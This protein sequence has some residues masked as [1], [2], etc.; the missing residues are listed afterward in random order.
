MKI[1]D[2]EW[3]KE[4]IGRT[5]FEVEIEKDDSFSP[6][7]LR[8]VP[9]CDYLVVKVPAGMTP[10]NWFLGGQHFTCTEMQIKYSKQIADFDPD[11]RFIRKILPR[12]TY[13]IV[14]NLAAAELITER[15]TPD[16]FRT[17]RISLDPHF[18]PETGC[19]RYRNYLMNSYRTGQNEIIGVYFDGILAGFE[20]YA[21]EGDVCH[22]KLGGIYPDVKVPGLGFLVTCTPLLFTSE[23]YGARSFVADV[24]ANNYSVVSLYEYMH[25]RLE[26]MTYV[27][28]KHF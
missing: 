20:M 23:R 1:I 25:F 16:M 24:S 6:D 14:D 17:D 12:V 2:C 19:H 26:G 3:E 13:Q 10:Y 7:F 22:G 5:V 4:N 9:A 27:F 15:I 18:G 21:M 8:D 11:D 28:A